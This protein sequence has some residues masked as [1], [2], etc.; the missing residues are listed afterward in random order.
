[1]AL[2]GALKK[3][4]LSNC[5]NPSYPEFGVT[6]V[7]TKKWI[8]RSTKFVPVLDLSFNVYTVTSA[9]CN[10][11]LFVVVAGKLALLVADSLLIT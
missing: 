8:F 3:T 7:L 9:L 1:M 2:D 10:V 11:S 4:F 5:P 6:L